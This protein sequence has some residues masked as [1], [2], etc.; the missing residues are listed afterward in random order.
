[1]PTVEHLTVAPIDGGVGGIASGDASAG[2]GKLWLWGVK[3][4]G[5]VA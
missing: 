4:E 3:G 5:L 1:M 2:E